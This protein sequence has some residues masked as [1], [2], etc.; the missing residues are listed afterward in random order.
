MA[1]R[2]IT[3]YESLIWD[4]LVEML[5][6]DPDAPETQDRIRT[7]WSEPGQPGFTIDSNIIFYRVLT[8]GD[9]YDQKLY[10]VQGDNSSYTEYTRAITLQMT[11]YGETAADDLEQIRAS[12]IG[13]YGILNLAQE[14]IFPVINPSSVIRLPELF[15]GQYWNRADFNIILYAWEN[16]ELAIPKIES[17]EI[18]IIADDDER[19]VINV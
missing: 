3:E 11:A 6:L 13:N 18:T 8:G 16:T 2:T 4:S 7:T 1:I 15:E 9:P 10:S 17:A 12:F 19:R 5:G 14:K